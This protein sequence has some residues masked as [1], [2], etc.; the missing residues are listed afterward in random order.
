MACGTPVV[1]V[2]GAG[3]RE[4]IVHNKTGVLTERDPVEFDKAVE[5]LLNNDQLGLDM[6]KMVLHM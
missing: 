4:T 6:E 3:V 2:A 5:L 1:G